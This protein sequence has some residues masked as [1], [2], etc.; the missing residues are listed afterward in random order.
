MRELWLLCSSTNNSKKWINKNRICEDDFLLLSGTEGRRVEWNRI[1]INYFFL[2]TFHCYLCDEKTF[3]SISFL[4]CWI[5]NFHCYLPQIAHLFA[6]QNFWYFLALEHNRFLLLRIIKLLF[7][8]ILYFA[9]IGFRGIKWWKW[10]QH[11][12]QKN[13]RPTIVMN[14]MNSLS[15]S[16]V[17]LFI[18]S[19]LYVLFDS[20]LFCSCFIFENFQSKHSWETKKLPSC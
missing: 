13:P 5:L 17:L 12:N 10:F 8:Y 1:I 2:S 4:L 15:L 18:H 16:L 6:C 20:Y 9:N 19:C 11:F 7:A 14:I 3:F